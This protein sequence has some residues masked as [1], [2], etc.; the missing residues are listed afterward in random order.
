MRAASALGCLFV[1]LAACSKGSSPDHGIIPPSMPAAAAAPGPP[2]QAS[3][4]P[5][6]AASTST[7]APLDNSPGALAKVAAGIAQFQQLAQQRIAQGREGYDVCTAKADA[8]SARIEAIENKMGGQQRLQARKTRYA[9]C[10]PYLGQTIDDPVVGCLM[11]CTNDD[12]PHNG[13]EDD[14]WGGPGGVREECQH[15][16]VALAD[17]AADLKASK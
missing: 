9:C 8:R 16:L 13:S 7:E 10:A 5:K 3:A 6:P 11:G 15:A 1:A 14:D 4:P 2:P 12:T 17:W